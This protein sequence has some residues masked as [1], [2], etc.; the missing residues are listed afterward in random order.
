MVL[1]TRKLDC[2][3]EGILDEVELREQLRPWLAQAGHARENLLVG[4]PQYMATTQVS[5]FP[6]GSG[7]DL[8]NMVAYETQQLAGLSEER[9]LHGY[10]PI[11]ALHGRRNAVL[12]GICRQSV[13]TERVSAYTALGLKLADFAMNGLAMANAYFDLYPDALEISG[14]QLLLDIGAE[15]STLVVLADGQPLFVSSLVF[16]SEK[17]TQA[18]ARQL[19]VKEEEAEQ[20]KKNIALDPTDAQSP[21]YQATRLLEN[22]LRTA[23]DHWR[24]QERPEIASRM[25]AKICLTGGGAQQTGLAD[26]LSRSFACEAEIIGFPVPD[27]EPVERDPTLLTAYGLALQGLERARVNVSLAPDMLK[28][29]LLRR[30]SFGQLVA[31]VVIGF[32]LLGGWLYK[33][34]DDLTKARDQLGLDL[35]RLGACEEVIPELEKQ[36]EEIRHRERMLVPIVDRGNRAR[37]YIRAIHKLAEAKGGADDWFIYLADL[38]SFRAG[39]LDDQKPKPEASAPE[40]A[41]L[42]AAALFRMDMDGDEEAPDNAF[43]DRVYV[44][45]ILPLTA[46]IA[47]AYTKRNPEDSY[48]SRRE[49]VEKL[50][51]S[52]GDGETSGDDAQGP[53]FRNVDLLPGSE[54]GP[55]ELDVF[56]PWQG[57][58]VRRKY[59]WFALR[60]PF[61][62]VDINVAARREEREGG[63]G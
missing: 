16:A 62:Q 56:G 8:A 6:E 63:G 52:D 17:Y 4:V 15:N 36:R 38:E 12:I 29:L 58:L 23:V 19:G 53:V 45:D 35:A 21:V 46:L 44:D 34:Y 40:L 28:W 49:I 39:K 22:E 55:R 14:P 26:Y 10:H 33:T 5:D 54:L 61:A 1:D 37:K 11:G 31:A 59:K 57:I 60:L 32:L 24:S 30:Q 27:T 9:F 13:I 42:D 41:R 2:R 18:V 43:P 25:F 7:A 48:K 20:A 3:E 47:G 50:N 51:A